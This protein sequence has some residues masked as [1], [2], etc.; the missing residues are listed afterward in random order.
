MCKHYDSAGCGV[1]GWESYYNK[2][3][4]SGR[5]NAANSG[6]PVDE[7]GLC[8]FHSSDIEWKR[9]NKYAER[10]AALIT[11]VDNDEDMEDISFDDFILVGNDTLDRET[12]E[13]HDYKLDSPMST[14]CISMARP[15]ARI[16]Y[17]TMPDF[18]IRSSSKRVSLKQTLLSTIASSKKAFR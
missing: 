15:A 4:A 16:W 12:W 18:M 7:N 5:N 3:I 8:L 11:C 2:H 10:L 14:S 13:K 9:Q 17:F 6:L 1:C